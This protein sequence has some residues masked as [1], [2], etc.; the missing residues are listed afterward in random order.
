MPPPAGVPSPMLWGTEDHLRDLFGDAVESLDVTER[1]FTF[2]FPSAEHFV[3]FFRLWYGPTLKAFAA[4][5]DA[6]REALE[7]DLIELARARP[8]GSA[9]RDR[10]PRD[11]HGGDRRPALSRP[12]DPHP[13]TRT[14]EE[15]N[16]MNTTLPAVRA[17]RGALVVSALVV[18]LF[19]ANLA[20]GTRPANAAVTARVQAGTLKIVGDDAGD[21]LLLGLASPTTL[22]VD[23]GEDGTADFTLRP[24]HVHRDRR[25]G[26][27]RRRRGAGRPERRHFTDEAVT[28]NGGGGNDT[29]IGG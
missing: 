20:L 6:G 24:Q 9:R 3:T 23:V 15:H 8:T 12:S 22:A 28:I 18:G 7:A 26:G 11:L 17:R 25:P 10:D 1:T 5:D 2:R 29:L 19:A 4:L 13:T 14:R 21:K 27:R 16:A